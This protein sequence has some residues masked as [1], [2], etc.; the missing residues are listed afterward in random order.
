MK[1]KFLALLTA[2]IVAVTPVTA[3]ALDYYVPENAETI[4]ARFAVTESNEY[5]TV[6]TMENED[7]LTIEV[8]EETILY[9]EDYIVIDDETG[10]ATKMVRDLLFD[11]TVA[12]VL[13][14]RNMRVILN[15][16]GEVISIKVLF[17][18]IA[19]GPAEVSPE[20]VA[21]ALAAETDE[22]CEDCE[23]EESLEIA[24]YIGGLTA[25]ILEP[26]TEGEYLPIMTLPIEID[27]VDIALD[28]SDADLNGEIVV[29]DEMLEAP[30]PFV[31]DGVIMLP[32]RAIAEALGY[33]VMWNSELRSVMLGVGTHLWVGQT[34]VH[35][36][37]MA[38]IEI[39]TAPVIV[40]GIT[41][42]PIDFFRDVVAVDAFW[43]EGQVVVATE[44]DMY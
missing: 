28:L 23:V 36:G 4:T 40:D 16:D 24:D 14:G 22:A 7:G 26:P 35:R 29:N 38:P 5:G 2:A 42:V 3:L 21:A 34:E 1:R 10:E 39:S 9:F 11:R 37:R 44:S 18:A 17:E 32:L 19:F 13:E 30:A 43:F 33:N 20:E 41:F 15:E 25:P 31:Q 12:E 8:N 27:A 6:F